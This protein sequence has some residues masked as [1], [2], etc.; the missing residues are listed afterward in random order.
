MSADA[1][2]AETIKKIVAD[3]LDRQLDEVVEDAR[4]I[5]DLGADSLDQVELMMALEEEF[6]VEVDDDAND[7]ETVGD[8]IKYIQSKV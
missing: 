6:S 1:N 2:I 7:I 8:V 5:D 3:R 4:F